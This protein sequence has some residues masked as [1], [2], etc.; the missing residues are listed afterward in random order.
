MKEIAGVVSKMY[1]GLASIVV[2][3]S[4]QYVFLVASRTHDF[5]VC[6][7]LILRYV[8]ST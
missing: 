4:R 6:R 3:A 1:D 7:T 8:Y 5:Y 2:L